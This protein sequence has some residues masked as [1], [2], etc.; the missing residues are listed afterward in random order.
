MAYSVTDLIKSKAAE[1]GFSKIGLAKADHLTEEGARLRE[2]LSLRCNASMQWMEREC[3]KRSDPS[4]IV[5]NA[6][7]VI[8]TAMNYFTPVQHPVKTNAGKISR[9]AWGDDYHI[10]MTERLQKLYDYIKTEI[11]A[12]TGRI[13]AD[14]GPVMDKAWAV[15]S[16]IGWL[17]KHTN[18]ITKEFGSWVFLGE[19]ILDVELDY[20]ETVLDSCGKCTACMDACPTHAIDR[21]YL[22]DANKCISYLTIEHRGDLPKDT[23]LDL[24]NWVYGCDICQDVC[25]WNRF[26]KETNEAAFH[27]R[28]E[29]IA[30]GLTEIAGM[31]QEEFSRRFK[32]SPI[33]RAKRSGLI[34][35]AVS[36]LESQD[37]SE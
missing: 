36:V 34:R 22:L 9:Y 10:V 26:Q 24:Q 3:E 15:R 21:P 18:V 11:P 35:N 27:P 5:P 1:L 12:A 37:S 13:Y 28:K 6:K 7:T 25:P 17:G 30:P 29:N 16:G 31:T 20:N 33:K 8:C 23:A 2:W 19:I 32:D 4:R 14:T